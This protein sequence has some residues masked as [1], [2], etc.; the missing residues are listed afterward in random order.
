MVLKILIVKAAPRYILV[1][2]QINY[3]EIK[4]SRTGTLEE[5]HQIIY[6]V[7]PALVWQFISSCTHL[8]WQF[9]YASIYP[10][11]LFIQENSYP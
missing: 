5:F 3:L 1:V 11:L 10:K 7:L 9:F 4:H 2:N 8:N 6:T